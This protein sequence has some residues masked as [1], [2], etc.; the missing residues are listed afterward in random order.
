MEK[1]TQQK[2]WQKKTFCPDCSENVG[3]IFEAHPSNSLV[4]LEKCSQCLC[5]LNY[6]RTEELVA[7]SKHDVGRVSNIEVRYIDGKRDVRTSAQW[8]EDAA[9]KF[10][11]REERRREIEDQKQG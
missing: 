6:W 11:A 1:Q 9:A 2:Y 7:D 8:A 3:S 4:E 5:V 10:K